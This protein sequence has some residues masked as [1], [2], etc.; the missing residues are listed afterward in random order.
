MKFP[1]GC[2]QIAA[3]PQDKTQ[4][5]TASA[6][7]R[8]LALDRPGYGYSSFDPDRTGYT[9]NGA[10]LAAL[11]EQVPGLA[12]APAVAVLGYSSGGP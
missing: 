6:G 2:S 1:G 9:A 10:E 7:V 5:V 8:L 11:L 4:T 12:S 3:A